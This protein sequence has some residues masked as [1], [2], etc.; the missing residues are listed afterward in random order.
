M[1]VVFNEHH[2]PYSKPNNLFQMH[3]SAFDD[4]FK[5]FANC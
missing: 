2:F 5:C 3:N 1:H 4:A